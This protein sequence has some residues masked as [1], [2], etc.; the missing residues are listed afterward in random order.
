MKNDYFQ[1]V[2]RDIRIM[3][4]VEKVSSGKRFSEIVSNRKPF[5]IETDLFNAPERYVDANLQF[6]P[7]ANSVK[8]YGVQGLKGGAKR[9]IGYI[10]PTSITNN[11]NEIKKFKLFFPK[12]YSTDAINPPEIICGEPNDVC[13]STFLMIGTFESEQEQKN[14]LSYINTSFFKILLYFGKGTINVTSSVFTLIPLQDFT[15]DWTDAKLYKKYGLT[16]EEIDFIES[17]I[18]P[19]E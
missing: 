12:T 3:S 2:I 10:K 5:G 16:Q 8:I 7:Y 4:I 15:E 6:E 9:K 13:T 11:I 1:Y 17:M 19:M 18:R 14:C